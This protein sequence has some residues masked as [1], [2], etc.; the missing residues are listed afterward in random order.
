MNN[1]SAHFIVLSV[2]NSQT[3]LET[4]LKNMLNIT[5][6]RQRQGKNADRMPIKSNMY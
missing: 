6:H 5:G 1:I 2:K 3:I 4:F